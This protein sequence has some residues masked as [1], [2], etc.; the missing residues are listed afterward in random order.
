MFRI[1]FFSILSEDNIPVYDNGLDSTLGKKRKV[2]EESDSDAEDTKPVIK[3][4]KV[5]KEEPDSDQEE[6]KPKKKKK[7]KKEEPEEEQEEA[8][9]RLLWQH[10]HV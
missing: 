5:K 7:I 6:E 2:K 1:V 3:K 9:E 8:G 4:K 10:S